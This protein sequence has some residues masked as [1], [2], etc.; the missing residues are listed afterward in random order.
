[1]GQ[2]QFTANNLTVD[3]RLPQIERATGRV[4]FSDSGIAIRDVR[5]VLFGG[6][7]AV[8]GA[9]RTEGGVLVTARGDAT[10]AGLRPV[11][12]H[13][14]R[15]FLSGGAPYTAN[16]LVNNGSVRVSFE[17]LL[18]GVASDLP[19]PLAKSAQES[20]PLR[21]D[22]AAVEGGDRISVSL[23]KFLNAEFQRRKEGDAMVL[24]RTG[25][26]LNQATR[27]PERNGLVLAGTLPGLNLDAWLPLLSAADGGA[28][29]PA[30]APPSSSTVELKLDTLDAFGKRLNVVAL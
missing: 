28:P 12:D 20:M 1:A 13:P 24:Q 9:T 6:P 8:S 5:G 16:V 15:R 27:L 19:P 26:G 3:A 17:T 11:F 7:V 30:N 18:N 29:A 21:V 4:E 14:W 23:A 2:Y 10:V 25:V 22:I